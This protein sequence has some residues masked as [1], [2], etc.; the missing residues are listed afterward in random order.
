MK[1]MSFLSGLAQSIFVF[2]ILLLIRPVSA[3]IEALPF[4]NPAQEQR[5]RNLIEELR[6]PKCQN[7]T[8]AESNAPLSKDLRDI[9]YEK[10]KANE[11][12]EKILAFMQDRY[13]DFILYRPP[14][15]PTTWVLWFGPAIL[16]ALVVWLFWRRLRQPAKA[17][18]TLSDEEQAQ[19]KNLL[20]NKDR[21]L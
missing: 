3:E 20:T 2:S 19:L 9:V 10:I 17:E 11:S 21:V 15:R 5:Y 4:D 8:I 7:A 16:F 13:G 14:V 6:C 1:R 18:P 12:D